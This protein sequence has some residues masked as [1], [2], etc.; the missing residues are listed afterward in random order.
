VFARWM[1]ETRADEDAAAVSPE[2]RLAALRPARAA[3]SS[4]E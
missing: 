4:G 3:T 1:P 2:S